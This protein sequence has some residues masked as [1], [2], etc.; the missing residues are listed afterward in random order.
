M[1]YHCRAL[2]KRFKFLFTIT[3]LLGLVNPSYSATKV[4]GEIF[5]DTTWDLMGSP[6][7]MQGSVTILEGV[8]LTVEPGVV[9]KAGSTLVEVSVL[10]ALLS[11]GTES[12]P[13]IY[14]SWW[15]DTAGGDTNSDGD[16]ITPAP[17]N[18][19]GIGFAGA[20]RE[21]SR[22][23]NSEIRYTGYY[24]GSGSNFTI[25]DGADEATLAAG[26][27]DRVRSACGAC[28]IFP[29]ASIN[30]REMWLP[31]IFVMGGLVGELP[32]NK[33]KPFH[34]FSAREVTEWYHAHTPE[35]F[36]LPYSSGK[37]NSGPVAFRRRGINL[38]PDGGL[39]VATI[40][41]LGPAEL[42][43]TEAIF[44]APNMKN[45]SIHLFS[46][47][48]GSR[49]IGE[50]G[51]AVRIDIADMDGDGNTDVLVS[52]VGNPDPSDDLV[53]RVIVGRNQGDGIFAFRPIIDGIPRVA[54]ARATDLD[55][56]GDLDVIVA[57]FG[58]RHSGG[59]FV[60]RNVSTATQPLTFTAEK[61]I[62][63]SGAVSILPVEN[64]SPGSGKGFVVAFAQQHELVSSFHPKPDAAAAGPDWEETVLYRAP[65]PK[66]GI[67]NLE[68]VDL[69]AD[70]D[71]DFLLSHGDTLDDGFAYKP[72]QGVKWLRNDG[73]G[74]FESEPIGSLYGAHRAQAADID[75][76]GDLDVVA[77]G[78][79]PQLPIPFES[80][81]VP[82]DSLIWF[83]RRG[84]EWVPWPIETNY[85]RHTGLTLIDMDKDG[86]IDILTTN[87]H[88]WVELGQEPNASL[89][90]WRN[91]GP[92]TRPAEREARQN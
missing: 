67:S 69:D 33:T 58:W 89:Q 32:P 11:L 85:P 27:E 46:P 50:A 77:S 5:V 34:A 64:L 40:R 3:A 4:S 73:R 88:S 72:Y 65:H 2:G 66:W 62:E 44:I 45:G 54:D 78:F 68:P 24:G 21:T 26:V 28:H 63:R 43:G 41:R 74:A 38:R 86:R 9:V 52:D 75:G 87:N 15:D 37:P 14:T 56:D 35:H 61:V 47:T 39:E 6:Y 7:L 13:I 57:A 84:S 25:P 59:V 12:D 80:G 82:V 79:L 36:T 90:L 53:G 23:E 92:S 76:D 42:S 8:T 81:T 83:E 71:L 1:G 10:G 70:G 29:E 55:S 91:L 19:A 18:W 51:H 30:P 17:G 20:S 31:Q 60:L 49:K 16:A 22:L 48:Q